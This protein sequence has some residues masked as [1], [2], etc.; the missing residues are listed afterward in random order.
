MEIIEIVRR[1]TNLDRRTTMETG[2]GRGC[3]GRMD[4]DWDGEEVVA[5]TESFWRE[6]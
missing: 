3:E 5:P 4:W 1:R 6:R 2:R